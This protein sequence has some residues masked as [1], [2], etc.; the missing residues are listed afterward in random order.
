MITD[1]IF[2]L[3]SYDI[4]E[5]AHI[6]V[7][8]EVC[9]QCPH[10]ACTFVCPARCYQWNEERGR[11]DFAYESCLECGTC[12]ITCDRGALDWKYPRGGFGVRYRLT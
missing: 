4:D 9:R 11:V 2:E 3:V 5:E 6:R 1:D 12:L 8:N 10:R 7:N